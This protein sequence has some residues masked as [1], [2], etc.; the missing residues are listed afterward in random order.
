[1]AAV[2]DAGEQH[3]HRV[4]AR[5]GV[6]EESRQQG[7]EGPADGRVAPLEQRH[8]GAHAGGEQGPQLGQQVLRSVAREDA[9]VE[10][11]LGGGGDDVDRA[12]VAGGEVGHR[13]G[14]AQ[15]RRD[16]R[17]ALAERAQDRPGGLLALQRAD[18]AIGRGA[19]G[20]RHL[21]EHRRGDRREVDRQ[22]RLAD[23][24]RRLGERGDRRARPA[25]GTV[26][27]VALGDQPHDRALL[28]GDLDRVDP[29]A[30][31]RE[32]E[33]AELTDRVAHPGEELGVLSGQE[34][35]AEIAALLLV[36]EHAEDD[37]AGRW[38]ALG[39]PQHRGDEHRHAALHVE[40]A[41]APEDAL[42]N[43][44]GE[45]VDRPSLAG[46]GDHVD[47]PVEEQ[48][49]RRPAPLE[50]GDDVGALGVAGEDPHVEP[51]GLQ[52]RS[53]PGDQLALAPARRGRVEA[54][55]LPRQLSR[56]EDL[57]RLSGARLHY[58]ATLCFPAGGG[59]AR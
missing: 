7:V 35:G 31:H 5:V 28:L 25:E 39:R 45:R 41:A 55:Q 49:R 44:P 24:P 18:E 3:R 6:A 16:R 52:L 37:V 26:P 36:A 51:G 47:V 15:H 30:D 10:V 29:L 50:E 19:D 27:G 1:M 58:S 32:G 12:A 43:L 34:S 2:G 54:D 14:V 38:R 21:V 11:G 22:R 20:V 13:R 8:L 57:H 4:A 40:R 42:A 17:P 9:A 56:R 53:Q 48:R 59:S 33:A 46:H 23:P